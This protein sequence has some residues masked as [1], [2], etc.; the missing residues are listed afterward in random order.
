MLLELWIK[1]FA[2][3][4]EARLEFSEG[5]NVLTGETGAGKSI[6]I[7]AVQLVL[8]GRASVEYIRSGADRAL[9]EAVF[10]V[11]SE[12]LKEYLASNGLDSDEGL[13][14]LTR[15]IHSLG[16]SIGR[17]NNRTVTASVLKDIGNFLIDIHGQN[18]QYS[19]MDMERHRELLDIYGGEEITNLLLQYQDMFASW[20]KLVSELEGLLGSERDRARKID[21]LAF[22]VDE[23]DSAALVVGEDEELL[24]KRQ[25]LANAEKLKQSTEAAYEILMEGQNR[26]YPVLDALR[27][28][29]ANLSEAQKWDD[30]LKS[31]SEELHEVLY[32][33]EDAGLGIRRYLESFEV[34]Y[35]SLSFVE[36]RLELI[37]MLKRKYGAN[38][39]EILVY[40]AKSREELEKLQDAEGYLTRLENELQEKTR[41]IEALSDK[42]REKRIEVGLD[43]AKKIEKELEVLAMPKAEFKIEVRDL[44]NGSKTS[45]GI[46]LN[47][48][49]R[50]RVEFLFS[51]NPGE[52]PKP[53]GKVAS[54][55]ELSRILLAIKTI[56]AE[57]DRI[58]TI[59]FDEIDSGIGGNT[60]RTVG[61]KIAGI[62]ASKQVLCVTHLAQIAA[63]SSRHLHIEK[64][65]TDERNVTRVFALTEEE[66]IRELARML[67]GDTEEISLQHAKELLKG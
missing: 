39:E 28:A 63:L 24:K 7:D 19:V 57:K 66:K 2:L 49:G 12:S 17:V 37:K 15:E 8:G 21:L 47:S 34:D 1:D 18:E 36:E 43:L 14:I 25:I 64:Q 50:D 22:Q 41:E 44:P 45:S 5:F 54:G 27:E 4:D 3:V 48:T 29:A 59:I 40:A 6:I 60:A 46:I 16:R 10:T 55:G 56:L 53:L 35:E 65:L 62:A 51:A 58:D 20:R 11:E 67:S 61:R 31:I 23:I 26:G 33:L 32:R 30:E 42:M 38:I 13:V 52:P 9:V